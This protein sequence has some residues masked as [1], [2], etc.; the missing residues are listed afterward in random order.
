[1]DWDETIHFHPLEQSYKLPSAKPVIKWQ[2]IL[3]EFP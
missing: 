1:M 2:L 3:V